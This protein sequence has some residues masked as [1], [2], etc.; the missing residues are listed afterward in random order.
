[1]TEP[2]DISEMVERTLD[3]FGRVDIMLANAGIW[4][5]GHSPMATLMISQPCSRSMSMLSCA[6]PTPLSQA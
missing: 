6:A 3:R 1:M 5:R 4:I 2:A